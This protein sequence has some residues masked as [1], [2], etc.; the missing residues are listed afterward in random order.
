MFLG[1]QKWGIFGNFLA[2]FHWL[3]LATLV[4]ATRSGHFELFYSVNWLFL[5][6]FGNFH[7]THVLVCKKNPAVTMARH[8]I[9]PQKYCL[10][11]EALWLTMLCHP[12]RLVEWQN[13]EKFSCQNEAM[14]IL[15]ILE[16]SLMRPNGGLSFLFS[17]NA[18]RPFPR[19]ADTRELELHF[20]LI[21]LWHLCWW[22]KTHLVHARCISFP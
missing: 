10:I 18:S 19:R 12:W 3:H 17:F 1:D 22:K 8:T 7:L 11:C 20:S 6:L 13:A 14:D 15:L 9:A 21:P 5:R 4:R 16:V 2:I